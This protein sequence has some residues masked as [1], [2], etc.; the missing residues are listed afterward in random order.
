MHD[1]NDEAT[2]H[3]KKMID[4]KSETV[5]VTGGGRA[6]AEAFGNAGARVAVAEINPARA[7][8]VCAAPSA[9]R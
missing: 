8:A 7:A 3:E 1:R 9:L 6:I 5:L 2:V 4:F